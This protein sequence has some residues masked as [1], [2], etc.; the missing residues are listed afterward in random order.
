VGTGAARFAREISAQKISQP[1]TA[2]VKEWQDW[3][4]SLPKDTRD[5]WPNAPL[6]ELCNQ[7]IGR[8][9]SH[10]TTVFI[11]QDRAHRIAAA[12]TTSGWAMKY[13]G[14]LGD[15]PVIG[16][17]IYADSRYGAAAC[18]RTG[19]M[20]LRALTAHK[21]V[22]LRSVGMSQMQAMKHCI[23][24]LKKLKGGLLDALVIHSIDENGE[25]S[26]VATNTTGDSYFAHWSKG[27]NRITHGVA[28]TAAI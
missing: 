13:P 15:S 23:N 4:H 6:T 7:V 16:A 28:E 8:K 21:F 24:D 22:T 10:D 20:A 19:E 9:G 25:P 27:T 2:A 12:A 18:T 3:F 1:E 14:R 5:N 17:S 26:V 11:V